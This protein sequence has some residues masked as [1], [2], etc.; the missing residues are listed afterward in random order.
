MCK[1]HSLLIILVTALFS[2]SPDTGN[3]DY[4]EL[5]DVEIVMP[6]SL[7]AILHEPLMVEPRLMAAEFR[8]DDYRFEW[9]AYPADNAAPILLAET[10]NLHIDTSLPTGFYTLVYTV[11]RKDGAFFYRAKSSLQVSTP[12]SEGWLV[13]CDEDGRTRL[14]MYSHIKQKLY[15]DILPDEL[16]T[17]RGPLHLYYVNQRS[18]AESPFYLLTEEGTTRLSSNDFAWKEE[19][20]IAYEMGAEADRAVR[21]ACMA[22]NG[23]GKVLVDGDGAVYYCNNIMGDGLY[24][25]KR[26]NNFQV[27]PFVG[28]DLLNYHYVPVFLLYNRTTKNFVA[29]AEMFSNT[30]LLGTTTASDVSIKLLRSVYGF[31]YANYEMF[32]IPDRTYDLV[33]MENTTYDPLN[34]GIGTTYAVMQSDRRSMLYGFA[35]GDMMGIRY[36]KYGNTITNVI[37]RDLTA[38]TDIRQASCFA[39]SSLKGICYYAVRNKVYRVNLSQE[40]PTA[41]LDIELPEDESITCL[42]F[43]HCSQPSNTQFSY[44]LIVGSEHQSDS[45]APF[46]PT[47]CGVLR[48]YDGW[49]TEGLFKG[50]SP[51]RQIDGFARIR[52]VVFRE[53]ISDY[54]L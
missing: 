29:C 8:E 52:D 47:T 24:N 15:T 16:K 49:Y 30:D 51:I 38:C 20:E 42:K 53:I 54:E 11:T 32:S 1:Y 44:N 12:F 41:E 3:Y 36:E 45:S 50:A 10:R 17:R 39:F 13:L 14:D 21:P 27:A 19:Y 6:A 28:C 25:Q 26:G 18:I 22:V 37:H 33:W 7:S 2:C 40:N 35:L 5:N 34:I 9:Q 31:P 4:T 23:A 48:L 46:D 43:Y